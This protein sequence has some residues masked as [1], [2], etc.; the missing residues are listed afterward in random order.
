MKL[1]SLSIMIKHKIEIVKENFYFFKNF[2]AFFK[3]VFYTDSEMKAYHY[4]KNSKVPL[5]KNWIVIAK[6]VECMNKKLQVTVNAGLYHYA[7]NNPVRYIDPDGR[8]VSSDNVLENNKILDDISRVAGKGFYFDEQDNL[9]IDDSIN[10]GKNYSNEIRGA[11]ISLINGKNKDV[12]VYLKYSTEFTDMLPDGEGNFN[13]IEGCSNLGKTSYGDSDGKSYRVC[14]PSKLYENSNGERASIFVHEFMGH[15]IPTLEGKKG[16]NAVRATMPLINS[17]G[18]SIPSFL[19]EAWSEP[20]CEY[21]DGAL[22][23]VKE[24]GWIKK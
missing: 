22:P 4:Q 8:T 2:L 11:L 1:H 24:Q 12:Q 5:Q 6:H 18:L 21:H 9:Q 19:S 15:L 16:G 7:G 20:T 13:E 14:V 23:S 3:S 10:P 17:L